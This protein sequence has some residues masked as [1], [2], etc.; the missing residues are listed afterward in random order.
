MLKA[1]LFDMDG[2]MVDTEPLYLRTELELTRKLNI[3]FS[4]EFQKRFIG[5]HH[6]VMWRELKKLHDIPYSAAELSEME[7]SI[8]DAYYAAGELIPVPHTAGLI[9]AVAEAGIM[10]AIATSNSEKNAAN[11]VKRMGLE[12]EI[13][14]IA[15]SC[16]VEACKPAPDV[17][18]LALS[19]LNV[20]PEECVAIDD[21][22]KGIQAAK[23]AGIKAIGFINPNAG[24]QDFSQA[25]Y[26]TGDMRTVTLG[27][28]RG[29]CP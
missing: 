4:L 6:E 25:D 10:C 26:T 2:V 13:S 11:V 9:R 15:S 24:H 12:G 21:S 27:L 22:E 16:K 23:A 3:P 29:L 8:M 18:Y 19:E 5:V 7:D 14:F 28:L 1:V 17:F 20:K